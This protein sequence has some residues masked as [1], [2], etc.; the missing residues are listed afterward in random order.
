[1]SKLGKEHWM[2]VKRMFMYLCGTTTNEIHYQGRAKRGRLLNVHGF[3]DVDWDGDMDRRKF[4][5]GDVFNI[6]GYDIS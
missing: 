4:T 6:C 3:V 2:D 1:M 5:I